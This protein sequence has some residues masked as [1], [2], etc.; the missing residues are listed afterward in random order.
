MTDTY[1]HILNSVKNFL[2]KY[3]KKVQPRKSNKKQFQLINRTV[4]V[5]P[6]EVIEAFSGFHDDLAICSTE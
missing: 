5:T 6:D 3:L 1:G 2:E 4:F